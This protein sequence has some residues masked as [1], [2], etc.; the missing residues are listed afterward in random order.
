MYS[1]THRNPIV[2]QALEYLERRY[3]IPAADVHAIT[4]GGH[5]GDITQ[6]HLTLNMHDEPADEPFPMCTHG[7]IADGQACPAGCPEPPTER[8]VRVP[9]RGQTH[10][11]QPRT[12]HPLCRCP[13]NDAGRVGTAPDCPIHQPGAAGLHDV[14]TE[15]LDPRDVTPGY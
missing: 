7:F 3:G 14:S 5:A 12:A 2:R 8:I 10:D 4:I 13:R 9:M 1:L 6:I 11:E 15:R